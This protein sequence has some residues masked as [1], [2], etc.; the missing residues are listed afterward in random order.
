MA[1]MSVSFGGGYLRTKLELIR[2][3]RAV[4]TAQRVYKILED[5]RDVLVRR[6]N[7]LI[8]EA[9]SLREQLQTP[10][11]EMYDSLVD[12][13]LTMGANVVESIAFTIPESV[14]VNV[15][16]FTMMGISIP[17][18]EVEEKPLK[19]QYGLADT[20]V[21]LDEVSKKVRVVMGLLCRAAATESAVFR[22]ADEL[23][24]TQRLLNALEYVVIPRYMEAI[25]NITMVLDESER[26][27]FVKL[28]HIKRT[29]EKR[30]LV[31]AS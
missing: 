13:Y 18:I 31:V 11:S 25:K 17:T 2:L 23:K 16:S 14:E 9:Q 7:E 19:L 22:I 5:K 3:K 26:D 27:Y 29:L 20:T 4:R 24:K 10:V 6:L 28:K 8:D 15:S 21:S 1:S 30:K 12:A